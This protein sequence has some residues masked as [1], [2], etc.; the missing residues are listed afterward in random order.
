M[1]N[2]KVKIITEDGLL[3]LG[4]SERKVL[5]EACFPVVGIAALREQLAVCLFIYYCR[6]L[7]VV[8]TRVKLESARLGPGAAGAKNRKYLFSDGSARARSVPPGQVLLPEQ[9]LSRGFMGLISGSGIGA[10]FRLLI[11]QSLTELVLL[12][13]WPAVL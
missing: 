10:L 2:S 4:Y 5:C 12:C 9:D 8:I 1:Q 6:E 3:V 11:L 7:E 13:P